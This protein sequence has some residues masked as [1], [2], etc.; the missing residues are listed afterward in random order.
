M[1]WS[2]RLGQLVTGLSITTIADSFGEERACCCRPTG[3]LTV[4]IA[5]SFDEVGLILV[6]ILVKSELAAAP[7]KTLHSNGAYVSET[8]MASIG[9]SSILNLSDACHLV[10]N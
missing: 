10:M 3:I 6:F 4:F 9:D 5:D 8:R 1:N 7:L 2:F